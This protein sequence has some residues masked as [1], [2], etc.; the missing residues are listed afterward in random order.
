[1][2]VV[3][4]FF[5]FNLNLFCNRQHIYMGQNEKYKTRESPLFL[6]LL[7]PSIIFLP[8]RFEHFHLLNISLPLL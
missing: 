3:I 1:M 2:S 7:L 6:L 8:L 4:L 5:K